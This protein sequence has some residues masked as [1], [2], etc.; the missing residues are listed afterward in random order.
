MGYKPTKAADN[1]YCKCRKN[2]ARF[3]EKL[4]SREGAAELSKLIQSIP[5]LIG[6]SI[7]VV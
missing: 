3:N 1:I 6:R 4:N 2:A 7:I 5:C